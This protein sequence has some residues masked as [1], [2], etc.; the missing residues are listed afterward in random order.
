MKSLLLDKSMNVTGTRN[1]VVVTSTRSQ[2]PI[3]LL[4]DR[5]YLTELTQCW[6]GMKQIS[7]TL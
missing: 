6:Y 1:L 5:N 4:I 3:Y 2:K 7:G